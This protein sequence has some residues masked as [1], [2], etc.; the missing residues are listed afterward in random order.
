M[1]LQ[2]RQC[3]VMKTAWKMFTQSVSLLE[4]FRDDRGANVAVIFAIS[5]VP[6]IGFVGAAL[7]YSRVNRARSQMLGALDST[8]LMVAKDMNN[9]IIAQSAI[10]S[11][12]QSYF[13]ALYQ[14]SDAPGVAVTATYTPSSGNTAPSVVVTGAGTLNTAFLQ[15]IGFPQFSFSGSSATSWKANLVRISLVLDNT[16]SMN[17]GGKLNS[18]KSAATNFVNAMQGLAQNN[19]DVYVS[20]VPFAMDVNVGTSNVN[21]NWLRWDLWDPSNYGN[22]SY[23]WATWCSSGNWLTYAQCVG[24]G[25][26]WNHSVGNPSK[27]QWTGCVTDRDQ[28]YDVVSTAPS[29]QATRFY[30]DHDQFC[31]VIPIIP[32]TYNWSSITSSINA[33]TAQGATNQ[34]IGLLWG[35]LSL[36]NQ[37]PLNAP[38]ESSSSTYQHIIV[39]FTDGLN[40]GDRW[41]GDLAN[42]SSSVDGR[43]QTL[44][45][46]IKSTG[47]TIYTIQIDTDGAGQSA[48][49]PYCASGSDKFFMLT[50]ASQIAAAFSQIKISITNLRVAK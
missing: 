33:M 29:A 10:S 5:L 48:V 15:V 17:S 34:P 21:A 27:S 11:T 32:L 8:A 45:D 49:L 46:N 42:Q 38:S 31:P 4:R 41:Y 18:L 36:L 22:A 43:M 40:T 9:G 6:L 1:T 12:A 44:C 26:S 50:D 37:N 16:G 13:N 28:S 20:L 14:N 23:P 2:N 35:W 47:V 30:A 24:R 19:G 3:G 25:Y 39:L 7:D